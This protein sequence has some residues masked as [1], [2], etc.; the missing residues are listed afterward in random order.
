MAN[1]EEVTKNNAIRGHI[2]ALK[3]KFAELDALDSDFADLDA[4]MP[5]GEGVEQFN[6]LSDKREELETEIRKKREY[7]QLLSEWEK[8]KGSGWSDDVQIE[9]NSLDQQFADIAGGASDD[10]GLNA[11]LPALPTTPMAPEAPG[12]PAVP[13]APEV[14][15]DATTD[16][17]LDAAAIE[18]PPTE[19]PAPLAE[20]L[21]PPMASTKR[22]EKSAST[23]IR[24][25]EAWG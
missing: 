10:M 7:I 15:V 16:P 3:S 1:Q 6:L 18:P 21:E 22:G 19:A 13:P 25:P 23:V 2:A 17:S 12:L 14:P 11:P 24:R 4:V 5:E 9:L 8:L 20:P